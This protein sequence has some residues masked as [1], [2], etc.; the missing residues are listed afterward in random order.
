MN[1]L[2]LNKLHL[3]A[4]LLVCVFG[5][6]TI[7]AFKVQNTAT[8]HQK[9]ETLF[10]LL[11]DRKQINAACE[12]I[13]ANMNI[14]DEDFKKVAYDKLFNTLEQEFVT[15]FDKEFSDEHI[16][17]A[18]AFLVLK[19]ADIIWQQVLSKVPLCKKRFKA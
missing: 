11:M 7:L 8:R 17:T 4:A 14:A 12:P 10:E 15:F 18:V 6:V 5:S 1:K 2:H 3:M 16:D 19:L 9:I 13:F